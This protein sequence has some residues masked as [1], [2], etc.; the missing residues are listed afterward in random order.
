MSGLDLGAGVQHE[1]APSPSERF[2]D[3]VFDQGGVGSWHQSCARVADDHGNGVDQA[4]LDLLRCCGIFG[5]VVGEQCGIVGQLAD[6]QVSA[7]LGDDVSG[8][9][10][11][12]GIGVVTRA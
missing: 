5:A 11:K 10:D 12:F 2:G 7:D 4:G 8:V 6:E 3:V 9:V 1:I